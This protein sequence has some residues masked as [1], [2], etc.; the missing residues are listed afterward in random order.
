M[1]SFLQTGL[2]AVAL[3]ALP[4]L[5]VQGQPADGE[6]LA[7]KVTVK[8]PALDDTAVALHIQ[9]RSGEVE[10][11]RKAESWAVRF[12]FYKDG[13]KTK[14]MTEARLGWAN[15]AEAGKFSLQAVDLDYLPLKG[16]KKDHCRVE[17][18]LS[19]TD[20]SG[21]ATHGMTQDIPKSLF[22]FS[23]GPGGGS[24]AAT[25][26]SKTEVPLFWLITDS[27]KVVGRHTVEE[28]LQSNPKGNLVIVT[29]EIK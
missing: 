21:S 3:V 17:C 16:S 2:A 4:W 8:E 24:F 13:I 11:T 5:P 23:K 12:D 7:K 15:G 29:L 27:S 6:R 9:K 14:T 28:V 25:A 22:D 20:V 1:R 26:S 10:L 19:V 18:R